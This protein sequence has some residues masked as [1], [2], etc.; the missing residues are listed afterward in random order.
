MTDTTTR[1]LVFGHTGQVGG[2]LRLGRWDGVAVTCLSRAQADLADPRAVTDAVRSHPCDVVVNAAA[3]TAVDRAETEPEAAFAI[4]RDGPGHIA[5]A[6]SAAGRPLIHLSTDYVFDGAKNSPY[7]ED[8]SIAP[9]NIYGASKAAGEA[10]VRAVLD[11]HVIL[12]TSWVFGPRGGNFVRTMLRFGQT[13]DRLRVVA[14][15]TGGPTNADDLAAIIVALSRQL[16]DEAAGDRSGD[17]GTYHCCGAPPTSWH[18]FATAIFEERQRLTGAPAPTIEAIMTTDFP[19]PARRPM[20]SVLDTGRLAVRF[21]IPPPDWQY[22]L[23]KTVAAL[24]RDLN[25]PG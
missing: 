19:T 9:L 10:A 24:L 22:G 18:G 3:Y 14:D 4:N 6:C 5:A 23:Q 11:R 15:Q 16:A 20:N 8:D 21:G 25:N 1:V 2:A 17:W 7:G 12:R 13:R